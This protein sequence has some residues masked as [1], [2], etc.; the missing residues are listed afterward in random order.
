MSNKI[1]IQRVHSQYYVVNGKAFIQNEQG[2]WVTP[3]DVATEEEKKE[4]KRF[5]KQF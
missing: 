1:K 2:E 4:F 3:F 5:L